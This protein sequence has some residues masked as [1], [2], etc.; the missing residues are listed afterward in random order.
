MTKR[1]LQREPRQKCLYA[2]TESILSS[3]EV[4]VC[5]CAVLLCTTRLICMQQLG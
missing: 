4:F 5:D 3:Q 2:S 1:P